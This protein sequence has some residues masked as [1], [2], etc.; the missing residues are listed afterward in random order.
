M[1][2]VEIFQSLRP[3]PD[4][5]TLLEQSCKEQKQNIK[6]A[7]TKK[8]VQLEKYLHGRRL[9]PPHFFISLSVKQTQTLPHCIDEHKPKHITKYANIFIVL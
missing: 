1:F 3:D 4:P 6:S 9:Q 8:I 2:C 7:I 5:E